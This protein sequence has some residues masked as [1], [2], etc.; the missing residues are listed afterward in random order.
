MLQAFFSEGL[1]CRQRRLCVCS[2][3]VVLGLQHMQIEDDEGDCSTSAIRRTPFPLA[4]RKVVKALEAVVRMCVCMTVR[5]RLS[6][7]VHV[8]VHACTVV[9]CSIL[10]LGC[11]QKRPP[12]LLLY[13]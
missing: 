10:A 8:H 2:A 9:P 5:P 1:Q 7:P 11:H 13:C 4:A 3:G 6:M 12:P